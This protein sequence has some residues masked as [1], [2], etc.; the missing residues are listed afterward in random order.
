M[1]EFGDMSTCSASISGLS[2]HSFSNTWGRGRVPFSCDPRNHVQGLRASRGPR[3]PGATA[4]RSWG[5]AASAEVKSPRACWSGTAGALGRPRGGGVSP[6]PELSGCVCGRRHMQ[7]WGP[8]PARR[9]CQAGEALS[10]FSFPQPD[11]LS[12]SASP[13][14]TPQAPSLPARL[15]PNLLRTGTGCLVTSGQWLIYL[16]MLGGSDP[17]PSWQPQAQE[18]ALPWGLQTALCTQPTAPTPF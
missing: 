17:A 15:L 10:Q 13:R 6:S 2:S 7:Q 9:R 4:A 14:T 8:G 12:T 18:A 3:D 11:M 5:W 1:N 16:M